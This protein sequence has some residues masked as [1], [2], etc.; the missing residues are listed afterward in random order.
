VVVKITTVKNKTKG[1]GSG[2]NSGGQNLYHHIHYISRNR[3]GEDGEKAILF[4]AKN[5]DLGR[6]D[7]FELCKNDRHHFRMIL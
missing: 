4:D 7:F 1:V 2:A 5:E 6:Q 3:A